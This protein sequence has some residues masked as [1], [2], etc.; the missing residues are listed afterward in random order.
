MKESQGRDRDAMLPWTDLD[1]D[2]CVVHTSI[3]ALS[4]C[5]SWGLLEKM[6]CTYMLVTGAPVANLD[7]KRSSFFFFEEKGSN[8]LAVSLDDK[9]AVIS[10]VFALYCDSLF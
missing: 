9:V 3:A 5:I 4:G 2:V 10:S 1:W 6:E 8:I 7:R